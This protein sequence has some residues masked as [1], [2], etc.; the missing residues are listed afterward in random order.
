MR[1]KKVSSFFIALFILLGLNS[2]AQNEGVK[3]L[4]L[5]VDPDTKLITYSKIIEVTA[6]K[7]SLF[8]KGQ[9]W[10][11]KFYKNPTSVIRETDTLNGKISGKH[12]IKIL[13]PADKKGIQTMKGIVQYSVT[14]F[15]KENKVKIVLSEL[16]LNATSYS[17]IEKWQDKTAKDFSTQNYFYLEQIDKQMKDIL[18]DFEKSIKEQTKGKKDVW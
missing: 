17:P 8:K 4:T 5:P 3:E 13:N 16:N 9:I 11:K 12:Q 2:I 6:N 1:T 18:A 14:T 10:F 7:D 15:Y